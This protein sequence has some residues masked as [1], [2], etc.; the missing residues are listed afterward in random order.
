M[1]Y[2]DPKNDLTFKK[3]FGEHPEVLKSFL[4]A[5][6]PLPANAP[7]VEITYLPV[8]LVP[9]IPVIKNSIVDVRCVDSNGRQF[10][11]EMQMLWTDSFKS[12]V[13][14]NASK[15]YI[16]QL[17]KGYNYK[18]LQPVY[19]LS[20]VNEIFEP[21]NDFFYHHYKMVHQQDTNKTLEGLELVF[22]ELPKFKPQNINDKKTQV[23][24]LRYLTEIKDGT[25]KI[26]E[27]LLSDPEIR[28]AVTMINESAFSKEEME[29]YDKYWD[30][31]SVEK[32]LLTASE[33]K[34]REIGKAEAME[35]VV[36]QSFK[37]GL[38]L[39]TIGLITGLSNESIKDIAQK[40]GLG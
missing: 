11:V 40:A 10:I 29:Y 26:S 3:V 35:T 36:I 19:A 25:E 20:L 24:W 7:I 27:D 37:N 8:E 17:D 30:T 5:L 22:V 23:L 4:N 18:G 13:L 12:R 31:I 21:E 34:G 14:F 1:R 39:E 38:P 2:L 6:L 28:K 33:E 15:A 16:R 9:E 32:T